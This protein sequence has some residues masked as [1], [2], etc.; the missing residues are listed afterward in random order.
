[1]LWLNHA[2]TVKNKNDHLS[3]YYTHQTNKKLYRYPAKVPSKLTIS[4]LKTYKTVAVRSHFKIRSHF[5]GNPVVGTQLRDP[6]NSGLTRWRMA[7]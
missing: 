5:L 4:E 2:L 1:M 3:G 6:I 7:V